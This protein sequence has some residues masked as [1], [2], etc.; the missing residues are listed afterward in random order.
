[1]FN[2]IKDWREQRILDSSEFAH[3]DW[4]RAAE[5][6][7][8]LDRLTE[9]ELSRLFD[10]ATL[11]LADKSITGAQG[12]EIT[13]T[14]R[15]S[16]ALQACLPIL[17]LSL[18]WYDGW[19]SII[20]YQGSYKSDSTTVD[21]FG[22]VHEGSQHRSG[23]AWQRGPVVLSWKDAKHSG[24]RDGHNVVIHEFVHKLDMMNGR[25]NGFPPLQPDMDP[26]RWTEIMSR[27]FENF[28]THR[29]SGLDRYG[30]TNP[31]EFFAVLSEVFFETPK[32]LVDAYPD[33]Y[34]IMVKFFR[35]DTLKGNS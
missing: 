30:A 3:E 29:K 34:D 9:D 26:T 4:A 7:V 10:L 19:S 18:E 6:I 17:N 28:Q 22:I 16:I 8:I 15:Q 21:E 20:I 23:E 24:E 31:A 12:F 13:D 27:D 25:A 35:Q 14:V 11:F 2:I 5:R 32:K 33:I 1:M